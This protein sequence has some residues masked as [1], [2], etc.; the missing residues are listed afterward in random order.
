MSATATQ[1]TVCLSLACLQ[2]QHNRLFAYRWHVCNCNTIDCLLIVGMSATATQ[3]HVHDALS[4]TCTVNVVFMHH[5][6]LTYL[7]SA[8]CWH[9]SHPFSACSAQRVGPRRACHRRCMS[10]CTA[11]AP[12]STTGP[13]STKTDTSWEKCRRSPTRTSLSQR[14]VWQRWRRG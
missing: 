14:R 6:Q 1:S 4:H 5:S 2:L 13:G 3:I 10:R 9:V 7:T 11:R 8:H 12:I